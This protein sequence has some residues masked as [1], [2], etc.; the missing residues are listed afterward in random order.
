VLR[1]SVG[2]EAREKRRRFRFRK[3]KKGRGNLPGNLRKEGRG[4]ESEVERGVE[5]LSSLDGK[6]K[7]EK[8]EEIRF[9]LFFPGGEKDQKKKR[10]LLTLLARK[11]KGSFRTPF[12][13]G[14]EEI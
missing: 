10:R 11:G 3:E 1:R 12:E 4:G 9:S 5:S 6:R 13:E 14:K 7:G 2:K 8:G